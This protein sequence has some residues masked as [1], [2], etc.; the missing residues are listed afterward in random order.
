MSKGNIMIFLLCFTISIVCYQESILAKFIMEEIFNKI[1]PTNS[2]TLKDLDELIEPN[3]TQC[4]GRIIQLFKNNIH[5]PLFRPFLQFSGKGIQ[6]YGNYHACENSNNM[7]YFIINIIMPPMP[8]PIGAI[9]ACFP[10]VCNSQTLA[11]ALQDYFTKIL[12]LFSSKQIIFLAVDLKS[13]HAVLNDTSN[14]FYTAI[15]ILIIYLIIVFIAT[16]R[17]FLVV[18]VQVKNNKNNDSKAMIILDCFNLKDNVENLMKNENRIDSKLNIFQFVRC[19]IMLWVIIGHSFVFSVFGVTLNMQEPMTQLM[20]NKGMAILKSGFIA[21]D[22][23]FM[24]SGFLSTM[25]IV[26]VFEKEQNR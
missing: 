16:A 2:I 21:V 26:S 25:A 22:T 6:Q 14:G 17:K 9:G 5:D 3:D 10:S 7:T 11:P 18:W 1:V 15:Y 24:L 8:M 4:K 19:L 20:M 23:F 12:G 13:F